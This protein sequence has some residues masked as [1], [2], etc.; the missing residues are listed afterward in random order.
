[1]TGLEWVLHV[2]F[3]RIFRVVSKES[4]VSDYYEV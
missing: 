4:V 3:P 2:G 1:M